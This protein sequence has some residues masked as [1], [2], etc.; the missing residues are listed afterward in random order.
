VAPGP[1]N[2]NRAVEH[3]A[4]A[5]VVLTPP[6]RPV[7]GVEAALAEV[8][9]AR[10]LLDQVG[11]LAEVRHVLGEVAAGLGHESAEAQHDLEPHRVL[12]KDVV[13]LSQLA[14]SRVLVDAAMLEGGEPRVVVDAGASPCQLFVR[15]RE[16]Y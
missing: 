5:L 12:L 11:A 4:N 9:R 6:T 10:V 8:T 7:V 14:Q 13:C 3:P 16:I 2:L 1:R 15:N